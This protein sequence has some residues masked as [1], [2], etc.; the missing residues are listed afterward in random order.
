M[1][2]GRSEDGRWFLEYCGLLMILLF[3]VRDTFKVDTTACAYPDVGVQ[4]GRVA[5]VCVAG[6]VLLGETAL[7]VGVWV[8]P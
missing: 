7:A 4:V 2:V 5:P 3:W 8:G 1:F 6:V